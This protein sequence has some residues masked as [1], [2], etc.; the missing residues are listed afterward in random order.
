MHQKYYS[1]DCFLLA[2]GYLPDANSLVDKDF[3]YR[4]LEELPKKIQMNTIQKPTVLEATNNPGLE[5]YVPIDESNITI[6]TYTNH[7]RFVACVH[8]CSDFN[9]QDVLKFLMESFQTNK[10]TYSYLHEA[11]FAPW[12]ES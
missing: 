12:E 7:P 10:I 1:G 6:S 8:S 11:D 5:G 4:V 9:Y 2:T 3:L